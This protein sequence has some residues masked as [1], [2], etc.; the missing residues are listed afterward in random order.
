MF[1]LI[2]RENLLLAE[3]E[4]IQALPIGV[5]DGL[6]YF[7]AIRWKLGIDDL[8]L[9]KYL[10]YK[11]LKSFFMNG[12]KI[13]DECKILSKHKKSTDKV[14]LPILCVTVKSVTIAT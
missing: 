2:L 8:G 5:H 1:F 13:M 11:K 4:N 7:Q 10:W 12:Y 9:G 14:A 6:R 3:I